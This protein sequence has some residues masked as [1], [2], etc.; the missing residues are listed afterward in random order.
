M[1]V[2]RFLI[3]VV[4]VLACVFAYF[5]WKSKQAGSPDPVCAQSN[6]VT[7]PDGTKGLC[8]PGYD[9][10]Y[11]SEYRAGCDK[12]SGVCVTCIQNQSPVVYPNRPEDA[13]GP[14]YPELSTWPGVYVGQHDPSGHTV[15]VDDLLTGPSEVPAVVNIGDNR[16]LTNPMPIPSQYAC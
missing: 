1:D 4:F 5:F 10:N 11:V 2:R 6:V 14:M 9:N 3:P 12:D 15:T 8:P 7:L 13:P 16:L